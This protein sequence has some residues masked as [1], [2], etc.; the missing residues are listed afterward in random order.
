MALSEGFH[1]HGNIKGKASESGLKRGVALGEGFHLHGN[2]KGKASESGLKRG[3]ALSQ[4][5]I[6]ME[7][8]REGFHKNVVLTPSLPQP[9]Q[10][11]G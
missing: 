11:M 5:F 3:V 7:T 2:I 9:V 10:F 1:L 6:D 8:Q 4:E